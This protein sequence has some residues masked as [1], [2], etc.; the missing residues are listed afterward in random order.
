MADKQL[1]SISYLRKLLSYDP[2]SGELTWNVRHLDDFDDSGS[3]SAITLWRRWNSRFA[4]KLAFTPTRGYRWGKIDG[5]RYSAH[6]V[7][8]ALFYEAWP[9]DR[10]DH[11]NGDRTDNRIGNLREV[12]NYANAQN[13]GI[14]TRNKSGYLGV[15]WNNKDSRWAAEIKAFGKK[16]FLGNFATKD[17]AIAARITA[18]A[19]LGFHPN[20]GSRPSFSRSA[21]VV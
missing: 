16:R 18:E 11:I 3:K 4:H 12:S 17:A 19:E 9:T 15:Y 13:I 20:H 2:T 7:A 10:I 1:H 5:V 14:G 8:W 6:W 21:E